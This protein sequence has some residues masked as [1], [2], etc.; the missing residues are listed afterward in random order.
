MKTKVFLAWFDFWVGFYYDRKKSILYVCP[1]PTVVLAFSLKGHD[2][3]TA[4]YNTS[5]TT[6][7]G[8]D[9]VKSSQLGI[10]IQDG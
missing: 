3:P 6:K 1:L 10:D 8:T 7:T 4:E 2:I 9:N 5:S